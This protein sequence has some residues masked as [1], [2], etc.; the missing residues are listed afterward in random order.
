MVDVKIGLSRRASMCERG[1]QLIRY[2]LGVKT[3]GSLGMPFVEMTLRLTVVEV[4]DY[5]R[6][7]N[8][9]SGYDPY[10]AYYA[11]AAYNCPGR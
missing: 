4:Q 5:R 7:Y 2:R 6:T 3:R 10:P 9:V 8:A 1:R 11:P